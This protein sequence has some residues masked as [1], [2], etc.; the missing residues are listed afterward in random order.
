MKK[1][2]ISAYLNSNLG[3]DLFIKILCERYPRT[4]FYIYGKGMNRR[5]F[6]KLNNVHYIS[7][8]HL[9]FKIMDKLSYELVHKSLIHSIIGSQADTHVYIGGS[10]FIQRKAWK[11]QVHFDRKMII[12]GKPNYLIGCNF[13]PYTEQNFLE[14][15]HQIFSKYEDVCFRD[16]ESYKLFKDVASTRTAP[17][18]VFNLQPKLESNKEYGAIGISLIDLSK[19]KNL[20]K[21]K[22]NYLNKLK[23]MCDYYTTNELRVT[24]FSFCKNQGD[25]VAVHE[26]LEK[27]KQETKKKVKVVYY[28]DDLEHVLSELNKTDMVFATRFHAMILG[29]IFGKKVFP[30]IYSKK[31]TNVLEDL[32][33]KGEYIHVKD[34]NQLDVE[35]INL[36]DNQVSNLRQ[37]AQQAARQFEKLDAIL[38]ES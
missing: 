24:L 3:D 29:F 33:F 36:D 9:F 25:E 26:L 30:I 32:N 20:E 23:E 34:I 22:D 11:K 37:V 31:M 7:S 15:Y 8:S 38:N 10:L 19:H 17:D 6:T 28:T 35:N 27:L 16:M 5:V 12:N 1:V 21:Y 18:V 13:G 14:S 2:M 4:N